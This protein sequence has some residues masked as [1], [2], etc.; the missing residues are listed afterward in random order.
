MNESL[1]DSRVISLPSRSSISLCLLI[2][3]RE[4]DVEPFGEQFARSNAHSGFSV[5]KAVLDNLLALDQR[6]MAGV[7]KFGE[8]GS[9]HDLSR[10]GVNISRA[11][12]D[13]VNGCGGKRDVEE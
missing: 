2:R 8:H 11:F 13:S 12:E 6:Q 9:V 3:F 4:D 10:R 7:P 1:H 5:S